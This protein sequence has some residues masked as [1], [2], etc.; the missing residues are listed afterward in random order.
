MLLL[1]FA[2]AAPEAAAVMEDYTAEASI[3]FF[4]TTIFDV[5]LFRMIFLLLFSS[6]NLTDEEGLLF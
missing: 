4:F 1:L 3:C 6:T 5:F 2:V